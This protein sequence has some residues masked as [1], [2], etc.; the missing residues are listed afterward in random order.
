MENRTRVLVI[1]EAA[2]P[3]WSSVP[4]IGWSMS[5]ALREVADVHVV[6]QIRNRPALERAGWQD[7]REFTAIDSEPLARPMYKLAK[8]LRL[9]WTGGTAIAALVY[10]Y[11]E[12]LVWARFGADIKAGRYDV[13][14][15]VTPLTPTANSLLSARCARAGVPFVIGPIN[16]G[17]PWPPSFD[18]ERRKEREWLSY[19]RSIYKLVPGRRSMLRTVAA[20]LVGSRA[21]AADIPAQYRDKCIYMPENGIDP[22]GTIP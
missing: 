14:H 10:P 1:A 7:G 6:T 20:L 2:N 22:Q 16:G 21:T 3:E 11:F 18:R 8:A 9:G 17:V 4:L 19:V 13:V 12:S 5:A 15:R